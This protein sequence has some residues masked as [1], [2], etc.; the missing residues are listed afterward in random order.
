M[1]VTV[2]LYTQPQAERANLFYRA[3]DAVATLPERTVVGYPWFQTVSIWRLQRARHFEQSCF[4]SIKTSC[5]HGFRVPGAAFRLTPCLCCAILAGCWT[6]AARL[7]EEV[8]QYQ[9][10][11]NSIE[12]K[13]ATAFAR[14]HMREKLP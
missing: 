11:G 13:I 4:A 6:A 9:E 7:N 10:N 2:L 5:S 12:K 1:A 8:L 14:V 3:W